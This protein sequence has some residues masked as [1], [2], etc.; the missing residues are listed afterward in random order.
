MQELKQAVREYLQAISRVSV[1]GTPELS[2]YTALDNLFDAIGE[3]LTPRVRAVVHY[4]ESNPGQPDL[5]FFSADNPQP[6]RGVVE[7][8]GAD[9]DLEALIASEQ[10]DTY[11]QARK[12]VLVT[13]LREFALVGQDR[14]GAKATLE[15][16][17]LADSNGVFDELLKHRTTAANRHGVSLGE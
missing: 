10:V 14:D 17:S 9:A 16:Y 11:W 13:N 5:G 3:A 12:L 2:H 1:V 15:C 6:D 8:K 4:S 7:V